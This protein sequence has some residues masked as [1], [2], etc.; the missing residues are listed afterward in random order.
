[1]LD[2]P[3]KVAMTVF[4]SGCD[5]ACPFCHNPHLLQATETDGQWTSIREY[6]RHRRTWID[7]VVI[8]GG[9]PLRDPEILTLL[10]AFAAEGI[11]VKLDTNGTNPKLLGDLIEGQLIS[12]VAVDI[13]TTFHRY[14][15]VTRTPGAA[16][17]VAD[18]IDVVLASGVPHEF[19]TTVYPGVVD[20]G[21]LPVIA[22]ALTGGDL[23]ALQ[24]FRP[25]RTLDPSAASV[26][27][28]HADTLRAYAEECSAHLPTVTR[29]A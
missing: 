9:E 24:Q 23:Y 11:P 18:T 19:R 6:I 28:I 21:E 20:P 14:D 8:S 4:L 15:L 10:E 26:T 16:L 1:M 5:F 22:S 13:K 12:A 7:G 27:P 2:W 17:R 3:G 29:G 25:Q